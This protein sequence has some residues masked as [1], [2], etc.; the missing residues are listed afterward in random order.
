M[1]EKYNISIGSPIKRVIEGIIVCHEEHALK[2]WLELI[3]AVR[4][5]E[6]SS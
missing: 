5:Q 2:A 4:K 1:E 6:A 3:K